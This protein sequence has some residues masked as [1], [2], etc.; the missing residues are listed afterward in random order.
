MRLGE[1]T[2]C[3][4][5]SLLRV[6]AALR[7]AWPNHLDSDSHIFVYGT[8]A[9]DGLMYARDIDV[10]VVSCSA[11]ENIAV[12]METSI[13]LPARNEIMASLYIISRF[14]LLSDIL[15]HSCGGRWTVVGLHG[16]WGENQVLRNKY[17][18]TCL[19][20]VFYHFELPEPLSADEMVRAVTR[21]LCLRY[22]FYAKSA[23]SIARSPE[24]W[25]KV[26]AALKAARQSREYEAMQI[27]LQKQGKRISAKKQ[28]NRYFSSEI[29][30]RPEVVDQSTRSISTLHSKIERTIG[31]VEQDS[32]LLDN[33]FGSGTAESVFCGLN[34]IST[35]AVSRTDAPPSIRCEYG[36]RNRIVI[37]E[38]IDCQ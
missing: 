30:S 4:R 13:Q 24:K 33:A 16:M 18:A 22:P 35:W 29:W 32:I 17:I 26:A 28:Q 34:S 20:S 31:V 2:E 3:H 8:A 7:S 6:V 21:V 12:R 15:E 14:A 10:F 19:A 27:Q 25:R 9:T 1:H 38:P 36:G 5:N 23:L 37:T 11:R